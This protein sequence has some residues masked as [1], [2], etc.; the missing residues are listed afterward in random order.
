MLF[1]SI[2]QFGGTDV[3]RL[4]DVPDPVPGNAEVVVKIHAAGVNPVDTYIRAGV[5]G[6]RPMPFTPGFD[7]AGVIESVGANCLDFEPGDRVYVGSPV[8][9]TYAEKCLVKVENVYRLPG[10]LSFEQGAAIAVPYATAHR[11]LFG[12]A[13]VKSGET[14]L[15]HGASGG[16]G[17]AA[18]QLALGTFSDAKNLQVIGTAGTLEGIEM[19]RAQGAH[20]V[21]NH[22]EPGYEAQIMAATEGRGVNVVLEMLANVNLDRDLDLLAKFGRVVIIGSRGAVTIDPRKTMGKDA[23]IHGMTL[24]NITPA[25]LGAIHAALYTGF[26]DET[27]VPVVG[28]SFA[29]ADAAAAHDAVMEPGSLG[30]IVLIP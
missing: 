26:F 5:Y 25:E 19:V 9:G 27:L 11:A 13:Q 24:F 17:L 22:R 29:L 20:H 4:E 16:V 1:R 10:A 15:V 3:L 23:S 2:H 12:K 30:K 28:K 21:F 6:D 18:V 14:I 8:T 7:A